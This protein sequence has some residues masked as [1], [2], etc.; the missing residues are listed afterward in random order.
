MTTTPLTVLVRK[1]EAGFRFRGSRDKVN[2]LLFMHDLKLCGGNE[3]EYS[4]YSEGMREN[5][6]GDLDVN[7]I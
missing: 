3:E 5:T 1:T 4:E 7:F 2:H 6:V